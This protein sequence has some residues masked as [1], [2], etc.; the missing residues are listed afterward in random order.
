L[1][2]DKHNSDWFRDW[3]NS[4][5]YHLLYRKRDVAEADHFIRNLVNYLQ[6]PKDATVWDLACGMGR[7]SI[8]LNS[9][10]LKVVGTDLSPESIEAASRNANEKLDFFVHDMRTPFRINYFDAV[11]NLFTSIG[12]FSDPRDNYAVFQNVYN[13]L[14]PGG[15]F[16]VDFF[17]SAKVKNCLVPSATE[18][19]GEI[20]FHINKRLEGCKIIKQINFT[21]KGKDFSFEEKV[22]MYSLSDLTEYA[23]K[24]GFVLKETFGNYDLEKFDEINSDRLIAVFKK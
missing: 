22:I 13:A 8:K 18:K 23:S 24:A 2:K 9:L 12:Y 17:N 11:L 16:V 14:K 10:G 20:T 4:P 5:Y 21:D 15:M 1:E 3:F 19:R 7:H 6:L